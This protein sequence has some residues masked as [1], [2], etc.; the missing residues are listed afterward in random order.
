MNEAVELLKA[1]DEQLVSIVEKTSIETI[2][3]FGDIFENLLCCILDMQ[4]RYRG[5]TQKFNKM[6][7][8]LNGAPINQDSIY[9]LNGEKLKLIKMSSQKYNAL[10]YLSTYWQAMFESILTRFFYGCNS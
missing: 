10:I 5:K 2:R 9:L 7:E 1:K 6:K 8:A 4:I 3:R